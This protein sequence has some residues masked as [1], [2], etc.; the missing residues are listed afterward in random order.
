MVCY[1]LGDVFPRLESRKECWIAPTAMIIGNVLIDRLV[2]IWWG[3]V[4][5]GDQELIHVEEGTNIQDHCILHTDP[6]FPLSIGQYTTI[7]HR[8]ILHGC[9]VG[10][11]ALVGM[12]AIVLNGAKIGRGAIIGAGALV[13]EGQEIPEN[14]LAIGAPARIVRQ[15]DDA[16]V[17]HSR[18]S[19]DLYIRKWQQ[20]VHEIREIPV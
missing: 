11:G 10:D 13:T 6:G 8:V 1:A 15:L 9:K 2:S 12:G 20:Y 14:V 7:G 19:A 3:A 18:K 4:L 16:T 17:H 5:R